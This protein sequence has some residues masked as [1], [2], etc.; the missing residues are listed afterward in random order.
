MLTGSGLAAT[1]NS[2][3]EEPAVDE[4]SAWP[5]EI[6]F[7]EDST[8]EESNCK[9]NICEES[10]GKE[11]TCEEGNGEENTPDESAEEPEDLYRRNPMVFDFADLPEEDF[12]R[13]IWTV[14]RL[15]EKY[16]EPVSVKGD[17][18]AHSEFPFVD[19]N[20][21]FEDMAIGFIPEDAKQFSFYD[22][23]REYA[24]PYNTEVFDLNENDKNIEL[25]IL[26]LI[27][28]GINAKLPYNINIG[29]SKKAKVLD[30]YPIEAASV[31]QTEAEGYYYDGVSYSYEFYD[32]NGDLPEWGGGGMSYSF[33][34]SE[35]VEEV[36]VWWHYFCGC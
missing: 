10:T 30:A 31:Y 33:N 7:D 20:L 35:V 29:V 5:N 27:I 19:V 32:E 14:N 21:V 13:G 18:W 17:L 36:Y 1:D 2:E 24:E 26:T 11:Q 12:P 28:T 4:G 34:R 23:S 6:L 8:C 25:S 16:G 22:E 15:I 9:E 3:I